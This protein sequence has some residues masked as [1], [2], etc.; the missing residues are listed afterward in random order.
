MRV[1]YKELSLQQLRTF[2]EVCRHGSYAKVARRLSLSTSAVWEQI[3][4]LERHFELSLLETRD[5]SVRPTSD[6]DLL[7][8]LLA[9]PLSDLESTK[10]MLRQ[11][12]GRH[13]RSVTVVAGMRM[14]CEEAAGA[15]YRFRQRY[16]QVTVKLLFVA[17][18]LIAGLVE[19]GEADFGVRHAT[20]RAGNRSASVQVERAY[21]LDY[22]LVTPPKHP[23][24]VKRG[25]GL[26]D[27]V[28]Y[29]LVLSLDGLPSRKR[30]EEI[31]E[32]QGLIDRMTVA[33]ETSSSVMT[34]AA[35]RSGVGVG[36]IA[37]SP[38]SGA[39][40]RGLGVRSLQ[41]WFG[42]DRLEFVWRCGTVVP[43]LQRHLADLIRACGTGG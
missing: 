42:K 17:D 24:A 25:L 33:V 32:R 8:E 1:R 22:V 28:R 15:A 9:A 41:K 38:P 35:V 39:L 4:G 12:G 29:P 2:R 18:S 10:E 36:I 23:L 14:L 40:T 11:L 7:L 3:R 13:P 5:G 43:P 19:R 30:V 31:F 21:E 37:G 27:V 20:G 16:P 6:G 26:R 34:V